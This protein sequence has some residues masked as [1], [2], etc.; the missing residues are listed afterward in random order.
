MYNPLEVFK[1]KAFKSYFSFWQ[2]VEENFFQSMNSG[3]QYNGVFLKNLY[4]PSFFFFNAFMYSVAEY[5]VYISRNWYFGFFLL[6]DLMGE[7]SLYSAV[8]NHMWFVEIFFY[9]FYTFIIIACCLQ[10]T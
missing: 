1:L 9:L 6:K 3:Y 8:F 10:F 5:Y 2:G 7:G 4:E